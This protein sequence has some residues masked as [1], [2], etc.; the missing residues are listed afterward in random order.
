M[1]SQWTLACVHSQAHHVKTFL[2]YKH[3]PTTSYN[4]TTDVKLIA[5]T[6]RI[7]VVTNLL[8]DDTCP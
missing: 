5:L 2:D 4:P 7:P 8:R 3:R 1:V 6:Q